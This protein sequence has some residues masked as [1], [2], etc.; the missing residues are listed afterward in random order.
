MG[1]L[2]QLAVEK[3]LQVTGCDLNVYPPMSDQLRA[4]G[5]ELV[6]GYSEEQLALKPD[7]WVIGNAMSRGNP[8][9]E[10]IL[11]SGASYVSGPEFLKSQILPDKW[12]MAVA[13]T[14]GKTS[15]SSMLAWVLE[16]A[17][18]N[19]G[20]LIGGVPANFGKSAR[21]GSSDFFVIE[22]D[23]YDTAFFDKRSKFVHYLPRTLI[24]NNLEFDHADIFDDLEA[25]ERQFHHL[26][27][28]VPSNGHIISNGEDKNLDRVLEKGCWSEIQRFADEDWAE[29]NRD[30]QLD[31]DAFRIPWTISDKN[32]LCM[33]RLWQGRL[34]W[35]QLGKHNRLN[36]L[37]VIA[38]ARSVGIEP[39]LAI[40]ALSQFKGV[41]RRMEL[42][43]KTDNYSIY[44]DF[45]HHPTAIQ[46]TLDGLRTAVGASQKIIA[47]IEPRSNTMKMGVHVNSLLNS[48][49]LADKVY[50]YQPDQLNWSLSD[51]AA[52]NSNQIVE[53]DF[54]HL[55]TTVVNEAQESTQQEPV[56]IVI[57][58]NGGFMGFHQKLVENLSTN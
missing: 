25:I 9:V 14:H 50:W 47:V 38:A 23:E 31:P 57:M 46:T 2:A 30:E 37:A 41:K 29:K 17:G 54:D 40:E 6:Q 21:L 7:L 45:A 44:D 15:T 27:R 58:S 33:N 35:S 32:N 20:F 8:L 10:A 1:S 43:V 28:I 13:G 49:K 16:Y 19:P 39:N 48:A 22:A 55:L 18:F 42:L 36:A 34:E 52:G 3:G 11:N 51:M 56:H 24:L 5:I 4:A 12:V 53:T 26:I